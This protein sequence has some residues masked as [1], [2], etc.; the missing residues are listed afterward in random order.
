M[1]NEE[2]KTVDGVNG[3]YKVSNT[4]HVRGIYRVVP[5][6][7]SGHKAIPCKTM[8]PFVDHYGYE[9]VSLSLGNKFKKL[10]VHRLVALAFLPNTE[11]KPQ[12]NHK[13]GDKLNNNVG[14]LEWSTASENQ[15]HAYA[16]GITTSLKG[17]ERTNHKL[18]T[19][20]VLGIRKD[21]RMNK[22]IAEEYGV[23]APTISNIKRRITWRHI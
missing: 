6:G 14:N 22:V 7:K 21:P 2:W 8:T 20:Q 5:H 18:T 16:T 1:Y 10:R 13:D 23:A 12:V 19:K 15:L 9:I 3:Y 17:E 11:N 4:G